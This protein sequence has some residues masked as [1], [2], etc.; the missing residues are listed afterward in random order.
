MRRK[1]EKKKR[2]KNERM[3]E[4]KQRMKEEMKKEEK[5]LSYINYFV[6]EYDQFTYSIEESKI[7][8]LRQTS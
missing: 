2:R 8:I 4:A 3:K 7:L 6:D 1:K 5:T